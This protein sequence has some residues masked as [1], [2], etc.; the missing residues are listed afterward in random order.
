MKAKKKNNSEMLEMKAK[1]ED[2]ERQIDRLE[3]EHR[4]DLTNLYRQ[5]ERSIIT[6]SS[7]AARHYGKDPVRYHFNIG[8]AIALSEIR[9]EILRVNK[10]KTS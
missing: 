4:I 5:L 7:K 9:N 2:L 10:V 3:S 1:V 6:S 8:Y